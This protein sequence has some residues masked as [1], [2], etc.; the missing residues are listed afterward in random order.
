MSSISREGSSTRDQVG[1][2]RKVITERPDW[3]RPQ[4]RIANTWWRPISRAFRCSPI[5]GHP[6]GPPSTTRPCGRG[7]SPAWR[8]SKAWRRMPEPPNSGLEV[9]QLRHPRARRR[10]ASLPNSRRP[11]VSG[12]SSS[13]ECRPADHVHRKLH[14]EIATQRAVFDRPTNHLGDHPPPGQDHRIGV[15][16]SHLGA[17]RHLADEPGKMLPPFI[18]DMK[19]RKRT[20][21]R[22]EI[23]PYVVGLRNFH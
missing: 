2:L 9:D 7:H 6:P 17:C 14:V 15:V 12:S 16:P 23:G 3:N 22:D 19:V 4:P 8:V 20:R 18:S 21:E 10:P 5:S 1:A 13:E 11:L